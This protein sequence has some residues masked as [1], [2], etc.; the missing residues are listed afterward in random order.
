MAFDKLKSQ[1]LTI[2]GATPTPTDPFSYASSAVYSVYT[3]ASNGAYTKLSTFFARMPDEQFDE[4][5]SNV[6]RFT[7]LS[8][9]GISKVQIGMHALW[10]AGQMREWDPMEWVKYW[11]PVLVM[12]SVMLTVSF[13]VARGL[14]RV[15][16][17]LFLPNKTLESR[18]VKEGY[19][20]ARHEISTIRVRT[21]QKKGFEEDRTEEEE[22]PKMTSLTDEK[23]NVVD[24]G[25]EKVE[26]EARRDKKVKAVRRRRRVTG[27][28]VG[29]GNVESYM[30]NY[31]AS[32]DVQN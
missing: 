25:V 8:S 5:S 15:V 4:L 1:V 3:A 10:T 21:A 22:E 14:V 9:A 18:N 32:W 29:E 7:L 13:W 20:K 28:K 23:R 26:E 11:A 6:P 17:W 12:A 30:S 24:R 19:E 27:R 16:E 31:F 2:V